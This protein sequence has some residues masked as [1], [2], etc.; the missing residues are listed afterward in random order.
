MKITKW[1]I[2]CSVI[3]FVSGLVLMNSVLVTDPETPTT[4]TETYSGSEM[5]PTI[6]TETETEVETVTET[7]PETE[8]VEPITYTIEWSDVTLTEEDFKLICTTV[9]CESGGETYQEQVMVSLVISIICGN[10]R[11]IFAPLV[12]PILPHVSTEKF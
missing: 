4:E 10:L 5:E 7:E 3:L 12:Y 1:L 11:L 6:E 2:C 9:F 8:I